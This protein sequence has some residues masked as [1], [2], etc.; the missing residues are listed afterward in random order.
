MIQ[1]CR[2]RTRLHFFFPID[3]QDC[4]GKDATR[5]RRKIG[6]IADPKKPIDVEDDDK[7]NDPERLHER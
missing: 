6:E 4:G 5:L 3:L 1:L 2:V 7:I